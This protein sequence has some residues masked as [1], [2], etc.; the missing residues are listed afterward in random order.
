VQ[1]KVLASRQTP[2]RLSADRAER[3]RIRRSDARRAAM[4]R[5]VDLVRQR[6]RP[7]CAE[8]ERDDYIGF[9]SASFPHRFFVPIPVG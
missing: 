2:K 4:L 9:A 5:S 7:P 1:E 6:P 3:R 8:S